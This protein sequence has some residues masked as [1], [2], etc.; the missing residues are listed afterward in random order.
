MYNVLPGVTMLA[1]FIRAQRHARQWSQA[2]LAELVGVK[3]SA[4]ALW[5]TGRRRPS[6]AHLDR[7]GSVFEL[8]ARGRSE[9]L[10]L[11]AA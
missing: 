8:D 6:I 10:T 3:R 5:E 2:E 4:L 1:E 11:A 7:L 9:L